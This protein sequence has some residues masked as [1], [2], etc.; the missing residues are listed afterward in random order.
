M[1]MIILVAGPAGGGKSTFA[2]KLAE[3]RGLKIVCTDDYKDLPWAEVP[4]KVARDC[5]VAMEGGKDV[6]LEG[7]RALS[8]IHHE[9]MAPMVSEFWWAHVGK[10]KPNCEGMHRRQEDLAHSMRHELPERKL[11]ESYHD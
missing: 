9:E 3:M 1:V 8:T 2:K 7:V 4:H 6:I 11:V 5:W 10:L